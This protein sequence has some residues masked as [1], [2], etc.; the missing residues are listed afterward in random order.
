METVGGVP[1]AAPYFG[2]PLG[3]IAQRLGFPF[4][5]VNE[6]FPD[7]VN[8]FDVIAAFLHQCVAAIPPEANERD[9]AL[10]A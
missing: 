3:R 8:R 2:E 7:V 4:H 1:V 6:I 5:V 10:D 9:A